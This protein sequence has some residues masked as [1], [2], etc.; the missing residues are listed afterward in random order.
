M[1]F[2]GQIHI[3]HMF[4]QAVVHTLGLPVNRMYR[5]NKK[6][7]EM[8]S[9]SFELFINML[10][11]RKFILL[12]ALVNQYLN[13]RGRFFLSCCRSLIHAV[14]L[15]VESNLHASCENPVTLNVVK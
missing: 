12:L 11:D 14:W 8:C 5:Q 2:L 13:I 10:Q 6:N 1:S 4:L 7:L 3:S 15:K 9:A